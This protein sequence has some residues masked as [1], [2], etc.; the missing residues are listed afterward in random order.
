MMRKSKASQNPFFRNLLDIQ[1]EERSPTGV[2]LLLEVKS[3]DRRQIHELSESQRFF[4]DIALRMA[5]IRYVSATHKS[6]R[7]EA[8]CSSL[9]ALPVGIV[10]S[11][12]G[13][14]PFN[15]PLVS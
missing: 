15:I 12:L 6:G 7:I 4:L 3:A 2:T 10:R 14:T 11:A 5:M 13:L 8:A 9:L 1:L